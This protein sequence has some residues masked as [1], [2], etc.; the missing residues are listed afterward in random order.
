MK[1]ATI[2][3]WRAAVLLVDVLD[4]LLAPLVL[5]V[6]VDVGRLGALAREEALEQQAQ[7]DR[8]DGGDAQAVADGGVG[9]RA[10]ALAEDALL[11]AEAD[12][13]PHRQ[14]VAAV[15]QLVDQ[16]QLLVELAGDL[17][18]RSSAV[19][20]A[21][22]VEGQLAQPLR[23]GRAVGQ[24]LRRVAVAQ[25]WSSEKPQRIEISRVRATDDGSSWNSASKACGGFSACSALG[26][27]GGRP[28]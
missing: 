2:A 16:G 27:S 20:L 24:L 18:R 10:A 15:V 11:A 26:R 4:H 23:R 21:R 22:A 1:L 6:E 7:A 9:G 14:E 25:L 5:D 3:A 8:V 19:A 13:L 17:G 28:R 12:D